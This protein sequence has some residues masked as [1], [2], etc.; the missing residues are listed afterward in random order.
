M[1]CICMIIITNCTTYLINKLIKKSMLIFY[2]F[3]Q[4][5]K[6]LYF[7]LSIKFSKLIYINFN[8]IIWFFVIQYDYS[9]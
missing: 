8:E 9:L 1:Y 4:Y 3:S 5:M 6:D 2:I 7:V